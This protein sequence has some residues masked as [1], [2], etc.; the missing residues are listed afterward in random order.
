MYD[1]PT[2]RGVAAGGRIRLTEDAATLLILLLTTSRREQLRIRRVVID[3]ALDPLIYNTRI[4][5]IDTLLDEIG[6]TQREMGWRHDQP[7]RSDT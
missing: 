3:A 5:Q 4:R 2:C 7:E 6:R 1:C